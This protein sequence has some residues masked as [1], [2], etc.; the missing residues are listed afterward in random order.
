[1]FSTNTALWL[2]P[3]LIGL[4]IRL[5]GQD[6][7]LRVII[8]PTSG[9]GV[10]SEYPFGTVKNTSA[11][12]HIVYKDASH[13]QRRT[14]RFVKTTVAVRAD[15]QRV[16]KASRGRSET[17]GPLTNRIRAVVCG[18]VLHAYDNLTRKQ[19]VEGR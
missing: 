3:M 13:I 8:R 15:V 18:V 16:V 7:N 1:M 10:K 14:N 17:G 11:I 9:G 4:L 12:H 6:L 2:F 19:N 5:M